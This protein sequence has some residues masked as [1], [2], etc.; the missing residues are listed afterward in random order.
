MA[1][2]GE[3]LNA[4]R[5]LKSYFFVDGIYFFLDNISKQE[6]LEFSMQA[7]GIV[8]HVTMGQ[9]AEG[10]EFNRVINGLYIMIHN[11]HLLWLLN[12]KR[13]VYKPDNFLK[14]S[15]G[16]T[17]NWF[18]GD[19]ALVKL[20][21]QVV[22][23]ATRIS[24]CIEEKE[25]VLQASSS[26]WDTSVDPYLLPQKVRVRSTKNWLSR[27]WEYRMRGGLTVL[28]ERVKRVAFDL[29]AL[30][31]SLFF[32]SMKTIDAV[33]AFSY[34]KQQGERVNELFVN[35]SY[36]VEALIEK[37]EVLLLAL[38][39]NRELVEQILK[40]SHAIISVDQLIHAVKKGI[41]QVEVVHKKAETVSEIAGDVIKDVAKRSAF[42]LFQMTG[43]LKFL[44]MS[45]VPEELPPFL[46]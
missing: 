46:Q 35:G 39:K 25:R 17:I 12:R 16:H 40:E 38:E 42:D 28:K 14:L 9:G 11:I 36:C 20:A 1:I 19:R 34:E 31:Q 3:R 22:T 43:F 6:I 37:K 18:F 7:F 13:R 23:I 21:A 8:N 30:F 45:W 2:F 10:Q 15:A 32:L 5:L 24:E 29:I 4:K 27:S 44:P 41:D 33:D 26:I